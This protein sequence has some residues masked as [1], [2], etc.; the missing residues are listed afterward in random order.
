[1]SFVWN[2]FNIQWLLN[3]CSLNAHWVLNEYDSVIFIEHSMSTQWAIIEYSMI[4]WYI[5]ECSLSI[6][7]VLNDIF[8]IWVF[9]ETI[10]KKLGTRM[11]AYFWIFLRTLVFFKVLC[12]KI[13]HKLFYLFYA[14]LIILSSLLGP[15]HNEYILQK[16]KE[17]NNSN[18]HN[19]HLSNKNRHSKKSYVLRSNRFIHCFRACS[20]H[21]MKK[22][23]IRNT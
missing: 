13:H 22:Y 8:D 11:T 15:K 21:K 17:K 5:I 16:L 12:S 1:M 20:K 3:E 10:T 4:N 19:T 14:L 7:W 18:T 6:Q 9:L 23:K 2:F